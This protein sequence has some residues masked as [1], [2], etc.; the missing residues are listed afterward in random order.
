M[1]VTENAGAAGRTVLA[2]HCLPAPRFRYSPVVL[3]A[4]CIFVSGLVGIDPATGQLADGSHAQA[5]Q[6]LSNLSA[7]CDEHGWSLDQLLQARV[8]CSADASA[9]DVNR[10]WDEAFVNT[11]PP[12]RTFMTVH[13]LPLGAAV[14]IEFVLAARPPSLPQSRAFE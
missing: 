8:Y 13:A 3:G 9:N 14:E 4:G 12:A 6:V 1:S 5:R 10:A 11:V 7:L 2:S